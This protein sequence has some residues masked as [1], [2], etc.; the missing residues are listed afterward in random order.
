MVFEQP[1]DVRTHGRESLGLQRLRRESKKLRNSN[2]RI[3]KKNAKKPQFLGILDQKGQ[4]WK[5]LA[6]MGKQNSFSKKRLEHFFS[7]Y[8]P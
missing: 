4:F 2:E 1:R 3:A 6:K 7:L 5:L 8:K